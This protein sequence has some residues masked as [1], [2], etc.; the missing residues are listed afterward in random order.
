MVREAFHQLTHP[1]PDITIYRL[2]QLVDE[3]GL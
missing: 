2:K 1:P 3:L